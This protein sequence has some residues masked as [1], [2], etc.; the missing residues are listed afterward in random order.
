MQYSVHVETHITSTLIKCTSSE[1]CRWRSLSLSFHE[2]RTRLTQLSHV[3]LNLRHVLLYYWHKHNR[4]SLGPFLFNISS[5]YVVLYPLLAVMGL[6]MLMGPLFY[7]KEF[8]ILQ[9][10]NCNKKELCQFIASV[11]LPFLVYLVIQ[12]P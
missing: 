5:F 3:W 10:F 12:K 8:S 11:G 2:T 7:R 4:F 1:T 9:S 6:P